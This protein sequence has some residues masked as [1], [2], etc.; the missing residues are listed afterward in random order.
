[1]TKTLTV[2]HA[3]GGP[4]SL[5]IQRP[6]SAKRRSARLL[7]LFHQVRK[8][9]DAGPVADLS[10][11]AREAAQALADDMARLELATLRAA[12]QSRLAARTAPEFRSGVAETT[13]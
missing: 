10:T 6:L 9:L 2:A 8:I 5:Q 7:G 12:A 1:V 13:P 4:V 11:E 3:K